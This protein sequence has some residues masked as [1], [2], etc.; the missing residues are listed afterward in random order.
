M[1]TACTHSPLRRVMG[2]AH[3]DQV[4]QYNILPTLSLPRPLSPTG[5]PKTT[6]HAACSL[7]DS[8]PQAFNSH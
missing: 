3:H 1:G 6:R 4:P 8:H 5:L 7:I 2:T